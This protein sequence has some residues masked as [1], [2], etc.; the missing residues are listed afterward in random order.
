MKRF[1]ITVV[2]LLLSATLAGCDRIAGAELAEPVVGVTHTQG[3]LDDYPPEQTADATAALGARPM[4]QNQY[5]MGWGVGNPEPSPGVFDWSSLDQRMQL[6]DTTHGVPV[7]TLAGAPDWMKG[8]SPGTTDWTKLDSAPTRAHYR[9]FAALAAAAAA[10]YPQVRDF[11]VWSEL[12]GLYDDTANRWDYQDYTDLYNAVYDAVKKVRPNARIGGPYVVLDTWSAAGSPAPSDLSG[13]WGVVDQRALD[14]IDYWNAH[15]HGADFLALDGSSGTR[16]A[17]LTTDPFRATEMF[18]TVTSWLRARTGLPVWWS[19]FYPT[20]PAGAA[21]PADSPQLAAL[22]VDAVAQALRGGASRLLL[23][24]PQESSDV[25]SAA[26]WTTPTGG[27]NAALLPLAV[28]WQWLAANVDANTAF[29]Y[30]ASGAVLEII[31]TREVLT[32]NLTATGQTPPG[33]TDPLPPYGIR[34]NAR[35]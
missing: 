9:D 34:V 30:S 14:V 32:V 19:E 26:L 8:G 28:P 10:R 4:A 20:Q 7:L 24:Q 12:K 35:S 29:S 2:A 1:L 3:S 15:K 17:G 21:W 6:I 16:D 23:W 11:Q 27:R 18:Y 25:P 33:Q 22:A 13:P 31:G 5:L